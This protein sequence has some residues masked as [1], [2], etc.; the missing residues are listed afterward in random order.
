MDLFADLTAAQ[1]DAV[2]PCRRSAPGAGRGGLGQDP[3]DHPPGR[4][5]ALHGDL[6]RPILALTFTNKAAGEMRERIDALVP[7]SRVWS[8]L[9][10]ASVPAC[11]GSTPPWSESTP[12]F[13]IYDQN[14]RLQAVKDV[15]EQLGW[16][17]QGWTAERVES[18][19]SRAKNDLLSPAALKHRAYDD[20]QSPGG[21]GLR[22]LRTAA[23]VLLRPS[24]STTSCP[25]GHDPQRAPGRPRR[26]RHADS[27]MCWLTNIKIRTWHNTR[28]SGPSRSIIPTSA[29]PATPISRSTAGGAPI[30]QHPRVRERLP[31]LPCRHARA[32]LP[33]HEKHHQRRRS[34]DPFNRNRKAKALT[35]RKPD[36]RAGRADDLSARDRRGRRRRGQDLVPGARGEY[37]FAEIAV[38]CR[39][40]ALTRPIE[41]A[42]RGARIP[43]QV[44]GGVAFYERQEVKDVLAYL[45][46]IV[47]PKDDLAFARV[48]NVPLRGIGK[49]SLEHL[50]AARA[51]GVSRSW[52]WHGR[53]ARCPR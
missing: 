47:N 45:N 10:T 42:F 7:N 52:R 40:T 21:P 18:A 37:S 24:T 39:V 1:R 8:A 17:D 51:S 35:N 36:W 3:R 53:L 12:S 22:A 44:V 6:R 25:P 38:F 28:S 5:P 29:S 14:D 2:T 9:F 27:A 15:M 20:D 33:Q 30:W 50:A 32:Q 4:P 34:P 31:G 49:T 43:Y 46:L 41:Q 48:V 19:I 11:F 23:C 13:S 16:D 26:S